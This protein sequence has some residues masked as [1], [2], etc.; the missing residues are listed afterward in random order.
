MLSATVRSGSSDNSW[1]MQ[2]MPALLA[3]AGSAKRDRRAFKLDDA[4]VRLDHARH[5]LDEGGFAGAV[6]AEHRMDSARVA[7]E[8]DILQRAHTAVVLGDALHPQ[9]RR[10]STVHAPLSHGLSPSQRESATGQL[11]PVAP[12]R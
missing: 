1:K 9:Q 11:H 3:A 12:E 7:F 4:G 10:R 2:T 6:F 5:D 8:A